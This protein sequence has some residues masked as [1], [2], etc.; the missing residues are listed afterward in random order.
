MMCGYWRVS[1]WKE[2]NENGIF[3]KCTYDEMIM[4]CV[5]WLGMWE[6]AEQSKIDSMSTLEHSLICIPL[7]RPNTRMTQNNKHNL[8]ILLEFLAR[9][10]LTL[11]VDDFNQQSI[12]RTLHSR[13]NDIDSMCLRSASAKTNFV[14]NQ[15]LATFQQETA[16]NC[17]WNIVVWTNFRLPFARSDAH[18][19][20][21]FSSP[22]RRRV[23]RLVMFNVCTEKKINK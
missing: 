22:S 18:S 13:L 11:Q 6:R 8:F 9:R 16:A 17:E 2:T 7:T 19:M 4:F 23:C 10:R 5:L 12:F 14:E 3:R 20:S 15:F 1:P 21:T